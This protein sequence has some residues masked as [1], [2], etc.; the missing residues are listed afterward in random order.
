MFFLR[1][2]N[3]VA[4]ESL[5]TKMIWLAD[6]D[7]A[8]KM[9]ERTFELTV[10][11]LQ[12]CFSLLHVNNIICV[13]FWGHSSDRCSP[14]ADVFEVGDYDVGFIFEIICRQNGR[15]CIVWR[16]RSCVFALSRRSCICVHS[17]RFCWGVFQLHQHCSLIGLAS[18]QGK[19]CGVAAHLT[20]SHAL[21]AT[22]HFMVV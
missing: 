4:Y 12:G 8:G 10:A 14:L 2:T 18:L 3:W 5:S 6:Q 16:S 7:A 20:K 9:Q 11:H 13:D 22:K 15:M 1:G 19:L 21:N 17:K